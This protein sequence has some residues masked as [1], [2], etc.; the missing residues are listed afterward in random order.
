MSL[1]SL[2]SHVLAG[3]IW[4]DRG[5]VI[6]TYMIRDVWVLAALPIAFILLV[7]NRNIPVSVFFLLGVLH[8]SISVLANIRDINPTMTFVQFRNTFGFFSAWLLTSL[9]IPYIDRALVR[10]I[11]IFLVLVLTIYCV[12]EFFLI[13][14]Y[15]YDLSEQIFSKTLLEG[16]K[17]VKANVDAG[18]FGAHRVGGPLFSP[19]QLGI[20][21][22]YLY[23][24]C[25]IVF[26][27]RAFILS[28]TLILIEVFA[29]S[30]T[31]MAMIL[32][33]EF[34]LKF[35]R[36][37]TIIVIILLI[38]APIFFGYISPF[39]SRYHAASMAYHFHG[40]VSGLRNLFTYPFGVGVG[41]GL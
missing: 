11:L 5:I 8:F 36:R 28:L 18:I 33:S 3:L 14:N 19:S 13:F 32:L 34:M 7:K 27:R 1:F 30:K 35:G 41:N 21:V 16:V 2:F 23:F 6:L 29:V 20:Y 24:T 25:R 37:S 9:Y 15:N 12:L 39:I 10:K 38:L 4:W 17:G 31:G 22:G 26:G 40:Y